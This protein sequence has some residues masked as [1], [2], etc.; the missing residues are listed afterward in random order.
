M[1]GVLRGR[2]FVS[3]LASTAVWFEGEDIGSST[4]LEV[5][6]RL[7]CYD[8]GT[9]L[10]VR[11]KERRIEGEGWFVFLGESSQVSFRH[12]W[13]HGVVSDRFFQIYEITRETV[14]SKFILEEP[15]DR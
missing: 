10:C 11:E 3:L 13:Q 14:T 6:C 12:Q 15:E 9:H 5:E 8:S 1:L 7:L 2:T 4:R